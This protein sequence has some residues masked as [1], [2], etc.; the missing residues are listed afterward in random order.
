MW[1][2]CWQGPRLH[3]PHLA[4]THSSLL[5]LPALC[6]AP[7]SAVQLPLSTVH[8]EIE[9]LGCGHSHNIRRCN[10]WASVSF[11]MFKCLYSCTV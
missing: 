11:G 1:L 5:Q 7:A 4:L 3:L 2:A 10:S 8:R 6:P 9:T